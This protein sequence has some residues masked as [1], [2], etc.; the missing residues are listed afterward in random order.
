MPAMLKWSDLKRSNDTILALWPNFRP[1][2][3]RWHMEELVYRGDK[4]PA[5]RDRIVPKENDMPFGDV[6]SD[7]TAA[8]AAAKDRNPLLRAAITKLALDVE[9]RRSLELKVDKLLQAKQRLQDE[10]ALMLSEATRRH[11]QDEK[12]D[13]D[14]LALH[15]E[16]DRY[17]SELAEQLAIRPYLRVALVG[18]ANNR[19]A[20]VLLFLGDDDVWS[21]PYAAGDRGAQ[22]AERAKIANGFGMG[23]QEHWGQ[24]K[25]KIRALL[26]P[27]ANQ[28]LQLASVQRMLAEALARG[29]RVLVSNGIVFWYEPDGEIGWRVKETAT[30]TRAGSETIWKEGTILSKNHGRLVVLPYIKESGELVSGHTKNAP[31]DGRALPRHPDC[32][33]EVPFRLYDGDLMI[34]LFGELPYE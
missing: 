4:T 32:Y 11:A 3:A 18:R 29:D 9:K 6:Y 16:S 8:V 34:G 33:V 12:W 17:R 15:P 22:I 28:L 30:A 27:R 13:E 19:W 23:A 1:L 5:W 14:A 21:K 26:L 24:V 25:A 7:R 2:G 20:N 31:H 10:E